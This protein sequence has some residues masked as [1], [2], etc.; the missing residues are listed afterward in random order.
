MDYRKHYNKLIE[1]GKNRMLGEATYVEKH[2]IVPKSEGGA[3]VEDNLVAL[4]AREHFVAHWLLHREDV[5]NPKR[6]FAFWRMCNGQGKVLTENWYVPSSRAYEEGKASW[7]EAIT[8]T[9][10]GKKKTKE[11][12]AKVAKAN[13]GKKRTKAA[14]LKMSTAAKNRPVSE[15]FYKMQ[16]DIHIHAAKKRKPVLKLDKDTGQVLERFDSLRAAATSVDRDS[17]NLHVAIKNKGTSAGY[18]WSYTNN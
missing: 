16:R 7:K 2:H 18:R 9:L 5:S 6:A 1:K 17:S 4:T 15:G 14:K 8:K 10:K 11:H 12:I 13:T 3:D